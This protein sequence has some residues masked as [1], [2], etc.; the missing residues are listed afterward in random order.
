MREIM[1]LNRRSCLRG[2]RQPDNQYHHR[3]RYGERNF[4]ESVTSNRGGCNH[5]LRGHVRWSEELAQDLGKE[6]VGGFGNV[7]PEAS[8][9]VWRLVW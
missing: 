1:N 3:D 7:T 2:N 5:N 4:A 9:S 8:L 6:K